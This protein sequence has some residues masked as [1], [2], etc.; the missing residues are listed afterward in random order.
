M[1]MCKPI[2]AL[3]VLLALLVSQAHAQTPVADADRED[4]IVLFNGKDLTGWTPKITKHEYGDN[5]ARTFRVENGL[6]EVR[7]D[8]DKY[9]TFDGQFGHLF[10]KDPFSYYRLVVEYR[11]VGQQVPGGPAWSLRNSGAM[12]HSPDPHT[13]P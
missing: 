13:M 5:Y 8:K 3:G 1:N 11:F 9:K 2:G 6:L 10:Y 12:L 7:Y 4:W